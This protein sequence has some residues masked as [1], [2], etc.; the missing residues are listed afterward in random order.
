MKLSLIQRLSLSAG[1]LAAAVIPCPAAFTPSP[2]QDAVIL[3]IRHAEKLEGGN[4]LTAAGYR[5]AEAYVNYFKNFQVGE[6]PFK[7]DHI[8]AAADSKNSHRPRLT[9]MP[10]SRALKL[11]VDTRFKE[12]NFEVLAEELR[13]KPTGTNILICWHHTAIPG[14]LRALGADPDKLIPDGKWPSQ[15]F[16]WAIEL[17]YDHDGKL[18]TS[19]RIVEPLF[20][21]K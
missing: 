20:S 21:N 19:K 7:I 17:R 10:L 9:V 16:N 5:R 18:E 4:E 14:L 8:F 6:Q 13:T 11:P 15:V 1:F 3:V 2:L 12:K